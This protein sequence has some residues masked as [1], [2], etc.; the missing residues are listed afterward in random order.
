MFLDGMMGAE[1]SQFIK[2]GGFHLE[3]V[4][5][6]FALIHK[7]LIESSKLDLDARLYLLEFILN[8]LKN[9]PAITGRGL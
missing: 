4:Q 7:V 8:S 9:T 5:V 2:K 6:F 1:M 3:K